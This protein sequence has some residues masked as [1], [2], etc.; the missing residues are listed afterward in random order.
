MIDDSRLPIGPEAKF[1]NR[2]LKIARR[3]FEFRFSSF[4]FRF[5]SGVGWLLHTQLC[6]IVC[7]GNRAD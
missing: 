1:E 5:S 2:N 6:R 4:E 3:R 7:G